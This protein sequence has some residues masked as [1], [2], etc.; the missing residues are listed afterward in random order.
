[1]G[2]IDLNN[3]KLCVPDLERNLKNQKMKNK[4]AIFIIIVF[5]CIRNT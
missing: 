4:F 2:L 3:F 1:M 5:F